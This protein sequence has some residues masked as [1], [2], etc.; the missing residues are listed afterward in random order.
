MFAVRIVF[1]RELIE[2]ADLLT[3]G[4]HAF[5]EQADHTARGD[6]LPRS[7]GFL[8]EDRHS[9]PQTETV[10]QFGNLIS[11]HSTDFSLV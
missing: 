5:Q 7:G 8:F 6:D 4:G 3:D 1:F 2:V 11:R 10:V 9:E